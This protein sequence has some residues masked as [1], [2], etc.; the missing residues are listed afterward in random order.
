MPWVQNYNPLSNS[1]LSTAVAA[2]PTLLLFY[3]LAFRRV[4]PHIAGFSSAMAA[5]AI[6]IFIIGMPVKL[7]LASFVYG[8]FFGWLPIGWIV[9]NGVFLYNLT[10]ATGQFEIIKRSI[11]AVSQDRRLQA[12]LIAFSFGAFIEGAA[13]FG[14]PIAICSALLVGLGFN[15]FYSVALCLIANTAP[16]AFGSLGIPTITLSAV[17]DLPLIP[18]SH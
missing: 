10:V 14:T 5:V 3:L 16:V 8:A 15:P 9:L 18:L 7:A 2:V 12:L 4:R 13:G 6:A 1:F 17:T 11:G